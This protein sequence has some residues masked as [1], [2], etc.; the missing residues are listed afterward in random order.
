MSHARTFEMIHFLG[1]DKALD[2]HL[3]WGVYPALPAIKPVCAEAIEAMAEGDHN[4]IIT[5][6]GE[7]VA[8]AF[9]LVQMFALE[10]FVIVAQ[11]EKYGPFDTC[12]PDSEPD[13]DEDHAYELRHDK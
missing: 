2:W 3:R 6:D 5:E 10:P 1:R 12:D 13:Y 8:R 7:E 9:Q 11:D 4:R